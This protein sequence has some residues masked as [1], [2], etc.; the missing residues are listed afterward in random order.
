[1]RFGFR[2]IVFLFVLLAVPTASFWFV[3]KPQNEEIEQARQEISHKEEMLRKLSEVTEQTED[4]AALNSEIERAIEMIESR[5][6]TAKEARRARAGRRDRQG[7]QA[8]P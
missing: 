1:M 3:F 7:A 2:E 5:L 8:E 6:P 4:L